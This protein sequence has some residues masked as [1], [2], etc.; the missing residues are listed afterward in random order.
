MWWNFTLHWSVNSK[1]HRKGWV[2]RLKC[3]LKGVQFLTVIPGLNVVNECGSCVC[4][5]SD[6]EFFLLG[7]EPL[8]GFRPI[9][10]EHVLRRVARR[11]VLHF[12]WCSHTKASWF[13]SQLRVRTPLC[14][15]QKLLGT[16]Q[17]TVFAILTEASRKVSQSFVEHLALSVLTRPSWHPGVADHLCPRP[18]HCYSRVMTLGL[19]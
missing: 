11:G 12:N 10:T 5:G 19:F 15:M 17:Q 8:L 2:W 14:K 7:F 13:L 9:H 3:C 16:A 1:Q 18:K 4:A 6:A